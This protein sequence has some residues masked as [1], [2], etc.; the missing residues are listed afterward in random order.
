ML[1]LRWLT[2]LVFQK[3]LVGLDHAEFLLGDH[4]IVEF[5]IDLGSLQ[6][7]QA[8]SELHTPRDKEMS[9][10]RSRIGLL[11]VIKILYHIFRGGLPADR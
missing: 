1:L 3:I 10:P 6:L 5:P 11:L 4:G 7:L 2:A 8:F 9:C